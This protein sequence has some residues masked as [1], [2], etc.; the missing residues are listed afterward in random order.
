M[1]ELLPKALPVETEVAGDATD[2][3]WDIPAQSAESY[4]KM[5]SLTLLEIV[6]ISC[7]HVLHSAVH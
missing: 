2:P 3:K 4:L 5:V 6:G 7:I 1:D